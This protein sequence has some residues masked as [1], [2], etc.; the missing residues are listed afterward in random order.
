MGINPAMGMGM[1][2]GSEDF[3]TQMLYQQMANGGNANSSIWNNAAAA[4]AVNGGGVGSSAVQQ[5][6]AKGSGLGNALTYGIGAGAAVGAATYFTNNKFNAPVK[7]GKFT[8]EFMRRF[9]GEYA[10]IQNGNKLENFFKG[11]GTQKNPITLENYNGVMDSIEEFI[12]SGDVD[13]L[14][15]D[16]KQVLKKKFGLAKADKAALEGLHNTKLADMKSFLT[17]THFGVNDLDHANNL[18]AKQGLLNSLDDIR[19]GWKGLGKGKDSIP[20]KLEYLREHGYAM[21]MEKADYEKLLRNADDITDVKELDD[22]FKK[23]GEKAPFKARKAA[24][25]GEVGTI[26]KAMQK[27]AAKWDK[28]IKLFGGG[29]KKAGN[30]KTMTALENALS[31][32]KK[33]KAGKYGAIAAAGAAVLSFLV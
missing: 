14:T 18:N 19:D 30:A 32:M 3:Y 31:A 4:G 21:G 27:F 11:L 24:L 17:D 25:K 15:D 7:D 9:S 1:M 12:K 23:F 26:E 28:N 22:I 16:A 10:A 2:G 13:D 8:P 20:A 6:A 33:G 5:Q 29:F